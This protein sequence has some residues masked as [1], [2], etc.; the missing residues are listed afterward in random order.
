MYDVIHYKV[1][2]LWIETFRKLLDSKYK[3]LQKYIFFSWWTSL[4]FKYPDFPRFS[5][6]LDFAVDIE[7]KK[8]DK[9][10]YNLFADLKEALEKQC[11]A[12]EIPVYSSFW[13]WREFN[14]QWESGVQIIKID[15]MYDWILSSEN[16]C[17]VNKISDLDI[18]INKL[19]RL[20]K[21]DLIDLKF[22]Y[23]KN[24]FSLDKVIN[25]ITTKS[26]WLYWNPY[27]LVDKITQNLNKIKWFKFLSDLRN[28]LSSL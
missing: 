5:I 11:E 18:F 17:G 2:Q 4:M 25:W 6:D 22:L 7:G 27:Y 1:L 16:C 21:T 24:K 3:N 15:F 14:F 20:N 19:Q 8:F 10:Y 13:S 23:R 12:N 26:Q 28:E 9:Y